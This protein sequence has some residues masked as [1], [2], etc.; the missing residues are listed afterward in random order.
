M[1]FAQDMEK[2]TLRRIED[3]FGIRIGGGG[4]PN[5][6]V[7]EPAEEDEGEFEDNGDEE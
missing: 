7:P 1:G 4:L 6:G 5:Y 3:N 2:E